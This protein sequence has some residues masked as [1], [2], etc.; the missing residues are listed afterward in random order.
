MNTTPPPDDRLDGPVHEFFGLSYA[1]YLVVPRTLMQSM[2]LDWQDAIV[3]C[4]RALDEAFDHVEQASYYDVEAAVE[5]EYRDL[6]PGQLRMLDVL[7]SD[8][9]TEYYDRSGRAHRPA[10]RA[11]VPVA[12]PVPHYN[13]GRTYVAP[14]GAA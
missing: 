12:D 9:R 10:D 4:L 6:T 14:G 7:A 2:P 3:A 1:N 8:D 5:V 11:L 13:R